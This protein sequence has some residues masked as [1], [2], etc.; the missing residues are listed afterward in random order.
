MNALVE[1]VLVYGY[2]TA[3]QRRLL[4]AVYHSNL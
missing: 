4:T 1:I 3:L 2:G